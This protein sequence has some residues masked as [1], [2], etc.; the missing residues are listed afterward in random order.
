MSRLLFIHQNFPAQF[1]HLWPALSEAGHDI[2]VLT[3]RE[4]DEDVQRL[5]RVVQYQNSR[6]NT[7]G[8]HPWLL[9]WETKVGRGEACFHAAKA[10]K[11][12][13]YVPDAIVAH[14]GWGESLFL[15][16]VWPQARL[17]V[18]CEYFYRLHGADV[19]FDPEFPVDDD[20]M[21]CRLRLKNTN[22]WLNLTQATAWLAPTRWQADLYPEPY[23]S[24]MTVVHDGI[25]TTALQPKQDVSLTLNAHLRLSRSAEVITFVNRNLEPLRGYH[26]FMRA[27]PALLSMRPAAHVLLVGGVG[28]SYGQKP[29]DA[30]SWA[31][32]FA[33]EVRPFMPA[34]AWQRVHFLGHLPYEQYLAVLQVSTVHVYLTYPFVLGWSLLEAM[35]IGCAVVASDTAPVREVVQHNHNGVL[36]NFFNYEA[37]ATQIA[38]LLDDP[39]RRL[40]LGTAARAHVQKHYDLR[41]VCLP[42]Q[43]AWVDQ[44]INP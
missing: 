42:K 11:A 7:R 6:A 2:T 43:V 1:R 10:L 19:G 29:T 14:P 30:P 12:E 37:L 3:P 27:L 40:A 20:D 35:S 36:V 4:Q 33:A 39:Q 22:N 31:E 26:T 9:D 13:G 17:G 38:T 5:V 25:D 28:V 21:A 32:K 24:Q 34:S 16:E 18:Y 8:I 23:R 44:L 41:R 15:K